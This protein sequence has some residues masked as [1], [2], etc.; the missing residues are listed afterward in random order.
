MPI[1]EKGGKNELWMHTIQTQKIKS[2]LEIGF[3][4]SYHIKKDMQPCVSGW[5]WGRVG[6]SNKYL[7][8]NTAVRSPGRIDV[9]L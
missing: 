7:H 6:N 2:V 8:P 3:F 1:I 5:W 9:W 4:L